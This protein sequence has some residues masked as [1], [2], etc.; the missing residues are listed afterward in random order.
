MWNPS[1]RERGELEGALLSL[2]LVLDLSESALHEA[3]GALRAKC[4]LRRIAERE[5]ATG[6]LA[7]QAVCTESPGYI[8][9]FAFAFSELK[10][11]KR[12]RDGTNLSDEFS[13]SLVLPLHDI[14][15]FSTPSF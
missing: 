13:L 10:G 6:V 2:Y 12:E 1:R 7:V 8:F 3:F 4:E 14:S 11:R 5:A 15:A 9:A